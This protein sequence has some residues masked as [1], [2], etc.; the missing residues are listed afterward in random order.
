MP[1]SSEKY[2]SISDL[3]IGGA[4]RREQGS[5]GGTSRFKVHKIYNEV[6]EKSRNPENFES[7]SQ[8]MKRVQVK[9]NFARN[10]T[11]ILG[12]RSE[13]VLRFDRH[14]V[15][16]CPTH[17]LPILQEEMR[18]R[19]GRFRVLSEERAPVE[20]TPLAEQVSEMLEK[21]DAEIADSEEDIE[22]EVD[23]GEPQ[24]AVDEEEPELLEDE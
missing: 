12:S 15:A 16:S 2:H 10:R 1:G 14:G 21:L 20:Q 17:L 3:A 4:K 19:P 7:R 8:P 23:E 9:S 18:R 5:G 13:L 11:L 24:S 6:Y 22:I